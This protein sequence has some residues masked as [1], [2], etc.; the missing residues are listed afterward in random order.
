M[1]KNQLCE[2]HVY[3]SVRTS[4]LTTATGHAENV[5]WRSTIETSCCTASA[6][7]LTSFMGARFNRKNPTSICSYDQSA[8]CNGSS[9]VQL[10]TRT[11][12]SCPVGEAWKYA[13][14]NAST[15][16]CGPAYDQS[17]PNTVWNSWSNFEGAGHRDSSC[18]NTT[19]ATIRLDRC[20]DY[21]HEGS[22]GEGLRKRLA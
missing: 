12:H 1:G 18:F 2:S 10:G 11:R 17:P 6:F 13:T 5:Q 15:V 4:T 9:Q 19:S 16:G 7:W 14:P 22:L 20:S 8:D 21:N 3:T